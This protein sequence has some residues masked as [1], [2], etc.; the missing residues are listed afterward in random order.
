LS[1]EKEHKGLPR[2]SFEISK[3][4]EGGV[5]VNQAFII[6]SRKEFILDLGLALPTGKIRVQ[7]RVITNPHD[8]KAIYL[9]L[10]ENIENYE[11]QYGP[12]SVAKPPSKPGSK[13]VH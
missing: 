11:R 9:A 7:A 5:Y 6:H 10:K 8:A 4:L 12:I 1:Q 13:Q 3:E 2:I